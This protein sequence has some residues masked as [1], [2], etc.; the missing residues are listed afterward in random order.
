MLCL[1]SLIVSGCSESKSLSALNYADSLARVLQE[2]ATDPDQRIGLNFPRP[3]DL[4]QNFQSHSIDLLEFLALDDCELQLVIAERNSSLGRMA[5][6][7]QQLVQELRFLETGEACLAGLKDE[8]LLEELRQ[9]LAIKRSELAARIWQATLGGMEFSA[10]WRAD[11]SGNQVQPLATQAVRLLRRDIERWL[12]GDYTIDSTIFEQRLKEISLGNWGQLLE[13]WQELRVTLPVASRV[14]EARMERRPLCF[15]GMKNPDAQ[16]FFQ[17]VQT[18]FLAGLQK[19]TA[20]VNR[21]TYDLFIEIHAIEELLQQES[22][23][24]Y[25]AW[26]EQRNDL[27]AE[28]RSVIR[29]HVALLEPLMQQCGFL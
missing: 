21:M 1:C 25:D 13:D 24:T 28:A 22:T 15:R 23:Q 17:V 18:G 29:T 12:S 11:L 26:R 6:A 5:T 3:R 27:V 7:S 20:R 14:L 19:D 10:S 8:Q 9:V 16:T 2:T 4:Q